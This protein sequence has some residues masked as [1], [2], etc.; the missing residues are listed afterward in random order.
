MA[1]RNKD[2]ASVY[3]KIMTMK[4]RVE[5]KKAG[6]SAATPEPQK[7]AVEATPEPEIQ[8]N[9]VATLTGAKLPEVDDEL[10]SSETEVS[11]TGLVAGVKA[12]DESLEEA[13]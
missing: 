9:L 13:V 11:S 7:P 8:H 1:T 12:D 3:R 2:F 6:K 10:Q 5:D 4:K